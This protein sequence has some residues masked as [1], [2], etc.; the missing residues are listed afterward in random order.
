[1][2]SQAFS[3]RRILLTASLIIS[4]SFSYEYPDDYETRVCTQTN[5]YHQARI[6]MQ[7]LGRDSATSRMMQRVK[8]MYIDLERYEDFR[9]DAQAYYGYIGVHSLA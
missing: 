3:A 2:R 5:L 7:N 8:A 6:I 4:A 1:M 9:A